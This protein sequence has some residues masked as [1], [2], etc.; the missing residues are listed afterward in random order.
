MHA[1]LSVA[2][3]SAALLTACSGRDVPPQPESP[4]PPQ[5]Q[6][7][8]S[9]PA[10]DAESLR[11][12]PTPRLADGRPDLN[13]T[14]A[15]AGG[16]VLG[17]EFVTPETLPDGSVCVFGCGPEGGDEASEEESFPPE[18]VFPPP[19]SSFPSYKPELQ[20]QVD[21]LRE[22]QVETDTVLRCYPPG[23]PRIGPP[24]K[25]VQTAREIVFLYNDYNGG[26][27]RVVPLDGVR[28]DQPPSHLGAAV[29][30]FDDDVLVVET[31]RFT[32]DTWLTDNGAFHT[33]ELRVVERL[34]RIGDTIDYEAV[35]HDPAVLTE[36]WVAR[37]QTLWRTAQE[38][39]VS[40]PC[41]DRD[42]A[43]MTDRSYHENPR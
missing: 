21:E 30:R 38:L 3:A 2:I 28:T 19:E 42:L 29:G 16:G 22:S 20:T 5:A 11:A 9:P 10:T 12:T 26:Y 24:G 7:A 6:A 4:A 25:I 43:S 36:P 14:W 15:H 35:A 23:V 37:T 33:A 13:G 39:D 8:L 17:L 32:T 34:R 31:T 18:D 1:R 27:F 40:V 41:E